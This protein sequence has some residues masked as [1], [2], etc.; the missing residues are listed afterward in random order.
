LFDVLHISDVNTT[1]TRRAPA[2]AA[3]PE[4]KRF[5]CGSLWATSNEEFMAGNLRPA[6]GQYLNQG[7]ILE[8]LPEPPEGM[9]WRLKAYANRSDSPSAPAWDVCLELEPVYQR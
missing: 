7:P 4:V 3:A 5:S 9:A 1:R 2:A 6:S 8:L